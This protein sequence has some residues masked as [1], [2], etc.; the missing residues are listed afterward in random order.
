MQI[1][2]HT[3]SYTYVHPYVH[4]YIHTGD[5][6]ALISLDVQ[7]TVDAASWPEF[8]R[9]IRESKGANPPQSHY[10]LLHPTQSVTV[11]EKSRNREIH[12]QKLPQVSCFGPGFW[13]L[14]FNSLL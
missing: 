9:E 4:T 12:K 2:T 3:Y 10:E 14:Q 5:V 1:Q 13:N 7:G 8:L 6:I 11:D